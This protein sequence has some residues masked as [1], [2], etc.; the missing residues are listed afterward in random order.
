MTVTALS[1]AGTA[2]RRVA[3]ESSTPLLAAQLI[4]AGTAFLANLLAARVLEPSGRGELALLLQLAYFGSL[5]V[6]LGTDRSVVAVYAGSTARAVASTFLR[7]LTRPSMIALLGAA[8][9]LS[10][11]LRGLESWRLGLGLAALFVVVN[12]FARAARSVAIVAGLTW[13]F[14]GFEVATDVLLLAQL[15]WLSLQPGPGSSAWMAGYLVAGALPALVWFVWS[16]RRRA[17]PAG[18]DA[19]PLRRARARREGLHLLP[20]TIAH[21]GT[22]R[23]D[24][25]VLVGLA[26]T[27]ALGHYAAVATMTELIAWPLMA[28]A[29]SRLGVWRQAHDR[30][31]LALRPVLVAAVGYAVVA[32]IVTA[33]AVRLLLVPLLGERYAPALPLVVPLVVASVVTGFSQL[34]ITALTSVH[35]GRLSS[36]V[37]V[38]GL[39]VSVAAY[40]V[41]IG[42]F[43][44]LGAAYGSLI[45]YTTC[46]VLAGVLL[47]RVRS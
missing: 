31:R 24:R 12:S 29:D 5:G 4:G 44:A 32:S 43:G 13:A 36:A 28:Y 16:T 46:L 2:A 19:A 20:A 17:E 45:G 34:L 10:L 8:A 42:R 39:V 37:E 15:G 30:G 40:V 14:L 1:W 23:L 21:N 35:R 47:A 7:L 22:L 9:V 27:A 25:L 6:V 33:L 11:P 41:L 18:D 3:R 26:S 38:V